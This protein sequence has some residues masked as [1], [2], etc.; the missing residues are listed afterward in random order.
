[1]CFH[2]LRHTLQ[3]S[4][5]MSSLWCL[6][7]WPAFSCNCQFSLINE[8]LRVTGEN[9]PA[10]L[11]VPFTYKEMQW[12][13]ISGFQ[14]KLITLKNSKMSFKIFYSAK[15]PIDFWNILDISL[16]EDKRSNSKTFLTVLNRFLFFIAKGEEGNNLLKKMFL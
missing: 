16:T 9:N 4:I 15:I 11:T 1:M 7:L 14:T 10:Q 5:F 2:C 8:N 13:F 3:V 6:P 12:F